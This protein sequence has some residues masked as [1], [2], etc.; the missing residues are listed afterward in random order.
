M[1]IFKIDSKNAH[2]LGLK[3][4]GF[5]NEFNL[6]DFFAE[7]LEEVLGV[8]F[9]E[10]EYQ[11]T[12]GRIDTLGIDENNSP[13]IIEYKWRENQEVFSQGLFYL[14]WL[15][16][17]K[18][19]FDLLVKSKLGEDTE[20]NWEQPR[21]ILIA[22]GFSRYIQAAAQRVEN[23][24]LMTY[25]LYEGN[26]LN[27]ESE[28][29]PLPENYHSEKKTVAHVEDVEYD[30]NYHL[31]IASSEMQGTFQVL[32]ER[33]LQLPS[34]EEVAGQKSGITYRTTKSF[35]RLEF[36]KTWIQLLLRDPSYEIDSKGIVKDVTTNRWGYKGMVKFTPE[37]D[38]EY[39]FD[40]VKASYESTL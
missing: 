5:G 9:L 19:H 30:L 8:R 15:V 13:V 36:R 32:R 10:K 14:D 35:T 38:I 26:I 28:Y 34:V 39:I 40:L 29:S 2:Q 33:L 31:N 24:E 21:V 23:V 22:Q 4:D 12:D 6:R 16:K 20:V 3:K 27:L 18:K 37:S 11:T 17:N 25:S 1:A 7:N